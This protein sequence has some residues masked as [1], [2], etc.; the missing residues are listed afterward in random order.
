MV[1]NYVRIFLQYICKNAQFHESTLLISS[2][3]GSILYGEDYFS[4]LLYLKISYLLPESNASTS[5]SSLKRS[6][7]IE[8]KTILIIKFE[9][10]YNLL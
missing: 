6:V 3:N 8:P 4:A 5:L 7:R 1:I 9:D 10:R 2:D